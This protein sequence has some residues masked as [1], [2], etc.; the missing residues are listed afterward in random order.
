MPVHCNTGTLNANSLFTSSA[1]TYNPKPPKY[2]KFFKQ[3]DDLHILCLQETRCDLTRVN[4]LT[5]LFNRN[6]RGEPR[7]FAHPTSRLPGNGLAIL[8]ND[9]P[10]KVHEDFIT[11]NGRIQVLVYTDQQKYTHSL[12]N[13]YGVSGNT[14]Q[15]RLQEWEFLNTILEVGTTLSTKYP[16]ADL[17]VCGDFNIKVYDPS[18]L[19]SE[20]VAEIVI[21]L[22]LTDLFDYNGVTDPTRYPYPGQ[23]HS[24]SRIDFI[25]SSHSTNNVWETKLRL[26]GDSLSDHAALTIRKPAHQVND[27]TTPRFI[28]HLLLNNSIQC[29]H[30][31]KLINLA[32]DLLTTMEDTPYL[33]YLTCSEVDLKLAKLPRPQDTYVALT[34]SLITYN[35][36][37]NK[38]N[39]KRLNNELS[40]L[41]TKINHL[42][43]NFDS[44]TPNDHLE[45][46]LSQQLV[47]DMTTDMI[48]AQAHNVGL[49][50]DH[51]GESGAS[52]FLKMKVQRLRRDKITELTVQD[53]LITDQSKVDE[54]IFDHFKS[55]FQAKPTSVHITAYTDP[56]CIPKLSA[57]HHEMFKYP[58]TPL[59]TEQGMKTLNKT[60]A[61][62]PDGVTIT[63]LLLIYTLFP[64]FIHAIHTDIFNKGPTLTLNQRHLKILKKQNKPDYT[65]LNAYRPISLLNSIM[66]SFEAAQYLK[67]QTLLTDFPCIVAGNFAY[68]K[69][70]STQDAIR[71]LRDLTQVA[72]KQHQRDTTFGMSF[73]FDGA[74]DTIQH[75]FLGDLLHLMNFP[76]PFINSLKLIWK[77]TT[78]II[79]GGLDTP[80][81]Q[82]AGVPQGGCFSGILFCISIL[83]TLLK[84]RNN[85]LI[86]KLKLQFTTN[87][88]IHLNLSPIPYS[89][90]NHTLLQTHLTS[91][92]I[93]LFMTYNEF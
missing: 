42:Y 10:L 69:G 1:P 43:R 91:D 8:L 12:L 24:P 54:A 72:I 70:F 74:F 22:N 62:G 19:G 38:N 51:L 88:L 6:V 11:A 75:K 4:Y 80:F 66:K 21:L 65:K 34:N 15:H 56:A 47:R 92:L 53:T 85:P 64:N 61:A 76:T 3:N 60:G 14:P 41:T 44:L 29:D 40:K 37:L 23:N 49:N 25:F 32:K 39:K 35:N 71:Q 79:K 20:R 16:Q 84:L 73:D 45:L 81:H 77:T 48:K 63:L 52:Y 46:D 78:L 55:K 90:D 31:T 13:V 36:K 30:D 2:Q 67:M 82:E 5:G 33:K 68:R 7:I 87:N 86:P 59:D 17:T 26:P 89:D 9:Y 93:P 28:D 18:D 83:P 50:Y 27:K 58:P 57:S